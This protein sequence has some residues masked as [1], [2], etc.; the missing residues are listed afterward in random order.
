MVLCRF[1]VLTMRK[2]HFVIFSLI[3]IGVIG[4]F[5]PHPPNATPIT[6]I[7][8]AASRHVGRFWSLTTPIVAM[9]IS[10][11]VIGFY[12][13]KILVS[14]YASFALIGAISLWARKY[15]SRMPT[16]FLVVSASFLFFIVTNFAT[17]L[18]SPWYEKNVSGLLYS[19]EL[20][21]PFLRNMLLGDVAYTLMISALAR[22][23]TSASRVPRL[24]AQGGMS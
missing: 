15:P 12:N 9:T 17:W 20:G 7:T 5:I 18:F 13:W 11:A 8:I 23:M 6:A 22:G 2:E 14:V 19:Y 21:V 3:A 1:E 16:W 24:Y 4:R 10:D